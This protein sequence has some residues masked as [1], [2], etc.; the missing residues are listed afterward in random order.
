[1]LAMA[2]VSIVDRLKNLYTKQAGVCPPLDHK[3]TKFSA[4]PSN[5]HTKHTYI[6]A[7]APPMIT[8]PA[9]AVLSV[10]QYGP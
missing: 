6:M 8:V 2:P 10:S 1:M 9:A 3:L 7:D 4:M 5:A